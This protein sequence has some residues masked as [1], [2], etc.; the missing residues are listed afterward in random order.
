MRYSRW[1]ETKV[2][3]NSSGLNVV[4]LRL[5]AHEVKQYLQRYWSHF[6]AQLLN[7]QHSPV[8]CCINIAQMFNKS[9]GGV[10][11][12]FLRSKVSFC[13]LCPSDEELHRLILG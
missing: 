1:S 6:N 10:L 8:P 13:R 12:S 7:V 5:I 4:R 9:S 2:V 11:L 3:A